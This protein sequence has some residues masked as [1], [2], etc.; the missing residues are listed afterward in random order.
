MTDRKPSILVVDDEVD[1]CRNLADIFVDLGFEVATAH[2]GAS[3]LELARDRGYDVALLDLI[4]PGMSGLEL[5][6]KLKT[7]RPGTVAVL[8]TAHPSHPWADAAVG[9]GLWRVLPKPVEIP[10]LLALFD[11]AAVQQRILLVDDDPEFRTALWDVLHDRGYRVYLAQ[12]ASSATELIEGE[13]FDLLLVDMKLP[14]GD[15]TVVFRAARQADAGAKAIVVTGHAAE[16]EERVQQAVHDGVRHVLAKPIDVPKL[17][18]LIGELTK[19]T[20][21]RRT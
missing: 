13:R 4:M 2:D 12:D 6:Q 17:L 16:M 14:D 7:V 10:H 1:T 18:D 3:A 15:G 19:S 5:Y 8:V 21:E 11:Q 9:A 20:P